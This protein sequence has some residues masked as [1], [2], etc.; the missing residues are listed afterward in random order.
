MHTRNILAL[1]VV[2]P[3]AV[4]GCNQ[5]PAPPVQP[6]HP[7]MNHNGERIGV[8]EEKV[9]ALEKSVYDERI[10][11]LRTQYR[12]Q[13]AEFDP[14]DSK[15]QRVDSDVSTFAVSVEDVA[16]FGDGVRVKLYLGNLSSATISG[17]T[18]SIEYGSRKPKDGD[19]DATNKWYAD[20]KTKDADITNQLLPGSWNPVSIVL[21][22]IEPKNFGYMV[23]SIDHKTLSLH[24]R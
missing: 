3:L 2:C 22:G 7:V 1:L 23:L 13:H 4:S 6:T 8:L 14:T 11:R 16:P 19:D 20:M 12:Y 18:L 10:E 24:K 21:P 17:V 15:F 5:A 9:R